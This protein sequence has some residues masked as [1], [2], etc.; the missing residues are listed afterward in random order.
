MTSR[1]TE[2]LVSVELKNIAFIVYEPKL[3]ATSKGVLSANSNLGYTVT[4]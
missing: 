4:L 3:M 2:R 1:Y